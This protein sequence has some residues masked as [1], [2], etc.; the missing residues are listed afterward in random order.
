M[1][2]VAFLKPFC[3]NAIWGNTNPGATYLDFSHNLKMDPRAANYL[4]YES[5][6]RPY[7]EYDDYVKKQANLGIV[8]RDIDPFRLMNERNSEIRH[9]K[10]PQNTLFRF[11]NPA[12]FA[13][14]QGTAYMSKLGNTMLGARDLFREANTN[15]STNRGG[16]MADLGQGIGNMGIRGAERLGNFLHRKVELG[17]RKSIRYCQSCGGPMVDGGVCHACARKTRCPYCHETVDPGQN[18]T[19][20]HGIQR[21]LLNEDLSGTGLRGASTGGPKGVLRDRMD[22]WVHLRKR[23]WGTLWGRE[24]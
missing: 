16:R 2:P 14:Y 6:F 20:T 5:R 15:V 21:N 8:K 1:I 4:R 11:L 10:L 24:P 18:H 13:A 7:F 17:F 12:A 3:K 19:C 23:T 9:Y 22:N